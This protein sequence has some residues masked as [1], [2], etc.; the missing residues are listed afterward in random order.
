MTDQ[1]QE[2]VALACLELWNLLC[3]CTQRSTCTGIKGMYN[4]A[5]PEKK[6]YLWQENQLEIAYNNAMFCYLEVDCM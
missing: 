1:D 3:P 5:Q 4:H 6:I 2:C